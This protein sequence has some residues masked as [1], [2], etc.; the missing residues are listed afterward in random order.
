MKSKRVS[1][2]S[3]PDICVSAGET[4]AKAEV[5]CRSIAGRDPRIDPRPGDV[6][7]KKTSTVTLTRC[8][9]NTYCF[10][11]SG[12]GC[13]IPPLTA[14]QDEWLP[15]FRKWARDAEVVIAAPEAANGGAR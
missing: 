5:N 9:P 6:L 4:A 14:W 13:D 10:E 12:L 7:R 3:L 2:K 11:F 1:E 15:E 8:E